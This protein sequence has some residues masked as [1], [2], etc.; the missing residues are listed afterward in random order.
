MTNN[1]HELFINTPETK[2]ESILRSMSNEES[3]PTFFFIRLLSVGES[4]QSKIQLPAN[5]LK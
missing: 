3:M 4:D 1:L 2:T 5:L